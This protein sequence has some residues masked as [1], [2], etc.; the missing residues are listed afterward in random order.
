MSPKLHLTRESLL[1]L[2]KQ[3]T[4]IRRFEEKCDELYQVEKIRGFLG[5]ARE[6]MRDGDW[7]RARN[8]AHKAEVL[9]AELANSP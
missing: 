5:Q 4:R 1:S 3:M 7:L 8:L 6:A 9:S 2:L